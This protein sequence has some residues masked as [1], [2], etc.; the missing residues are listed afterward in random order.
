MTSLPAPARPRLGDPGRSATAP[1]AAWL[2]RLSAAT[3]L[4]LY[5]GAHW[6]TI[7]RPGAGGDLFGMLVIALVAGLVLPSVLA[8]AS[9]RRRVLLFAL[10]VVAVVWLVLLVAH[11]PGRTLR[12]DRWAELAIGLSRAI[13][14]LPSLRV[15]YAGFDPWIRATLLT[16][17]GLLMA[18]GLCLALLPR[19][20]VFGAAVALGTLYAVPIVEHGPAHPIADGAAFAVLLGFLLWSDRVGARD[21]PL[22]VA[23]GLVALLA[24]LIA[25]PRI[26]S[27]RPW[28]DYEKLAEALQGGKTETFSWNHSYGPLHWSRD[29]LELARVRSRGDLYMKTA[30]LERFD[31]REWTQDRGSLAS[32]EDTDI[33][34]GRPG[35]IQRIHVSIRGLKS[36]QFLGSGTT[37][38][39]DD[40]SK[41]V[42]GATPGTFE[43][44]AKPLRRGDSYDALV[45]NPRPSDTELRTA[46]TNYP[47]FVTSRELGITVPSLPGSQLGRLTISFAPWGSGRLTSAQGNYGFTLIEPD[48]ALAQSAYARS[49]ALAQQLRDASTDPYDYVRKVIARVQRDARYTET[50]PAA[51]DMAPLEA[52]LFR[53]R[54]GY[55]QY[56][57]GATALLLRMGGVPARVAAGFSPGSRVGEDHIIRDLDAH[58]WVEVYFPHYGWV[59]YDPTPADS[60]ARAQ[61]TDTIRAP[62]AAPGDRG[63]PTGAGDRVSDPTAGGAAATTSDQGTDPTVWIV[64]GTLAAALLAASITGV[65]LRRRRLARSGDPELE[66]LRIALA[67]TGRPVTAQTTLRRLELLLG[68]SD[69]AL[70]YLQALRLARYGGGA[71]APTAAQRRALRRS[72]SAGLGL[73]ARVVALWALPPRPRELLDALRPRRRR[74]YTG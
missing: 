18:I 65:V 27:G 34:A 28:I 25:A 58:S 7:V 70:G 62:A 47:T 24:A 53:D 19:P 10:F 23:F 31:G 13:T 26:D 35:W 43:A 1:S 51:G 5:A 69:G 12:P 46:G 64:T 30:S 14:D 38:R 74:P 9:R 66:E 11:T 4:A 21:V 50:P 54:A 59:T 73:R 37:L 55:C 41:Q 56:F 29:G 52:F 33:A 20:R 67:R 6:A 44:A 17:G 45:Y 63:V 68:G 49:Y 36:E 40:S 71:P 22:A 3:L 48:R 61:L 16:G 2:V 72:L 15:P 57:A 39:I 42:R 60:P 32:D 8:V